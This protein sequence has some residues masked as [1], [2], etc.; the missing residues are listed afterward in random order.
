MIYN[1]NQGIPPCGVRRMEWLIAALRE[2]LVEAANLLLTVGLAALVARLRG[3][4][5]RA[6]DRLREEGLLPPVSK[7]SS[8]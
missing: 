4:Q 3:K 6:H 8:S 7:S 5:R 2:P 1:R